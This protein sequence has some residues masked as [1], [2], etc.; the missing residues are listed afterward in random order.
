MTFLN[1]MKIT[2]TKTFDANF[3]LINSIFL[4]NISEILDVHVDYDI[5]YL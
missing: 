5:K 1:L 4:I 3:F 2:I